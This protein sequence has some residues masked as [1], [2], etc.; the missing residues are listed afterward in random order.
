MDYRIF[1]PEELPEAIVGLP[2]S[3]S[4][5]N[6]VLIINAL[7]GG[8]PMSCSVARCDDTDVMVAALESDGEEISVG[9]AGTAMRF[10]TAY[11]A[12]QPGR[13]VSLDGSERMRRRPIA[14][15][16]DALRE[17]GAE[18]SYLG[19]EGFPP[20]KIVGK[21]LRGGEIALDGS[22]SSQFVSALLMVAPVMSEGLVLRLQGDVVSQPYIAMTLGIMAE[23]GVE[24]VRE[25]DVIRVPHGSYNPVPYHVEADWSAASYW[26]ELQSF[27]FGTIGLRGL[28][29]EGSLQG[30]SV[31]M[32]IYRNFGIV[33][34]ESEEFPGV[35]D[36]VADPD[37]TPRY[38]ADFSAMP[39]LAQTVG[40]SC[41]MLG[42]PFHITGL[43][44]LRIKETD[45][46]EALRRELMK[47]SFV[48][49]TDDDSISWEGAR[50]P[51]DGSS[52]I[53]IDTYD[54]HRMAMAFAP[55]AWY[56]PGLIIRNAEVVSKSYPDYWTHLRAAGF[57]I[58]PQTEPQEGEA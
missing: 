52:K 18:I 3:K 49:D 50:C 19:E 9:A 58:E 29:K 34:E 7:A 45:R 26:Y 12:A 27:S 47:I 17:C 20:L 4:I 14:P 28:M 31:L 30:D 15:L 22:V 39:D 35:L 23:W 36:L 24:S 2:L 8:A 46:L 1:P 6:R 51:V 37:M 21:S 11:F 44:T 33:T 40:V 56:V 32:K 53:A 13:T 55:V 54:D 25:G 10:L 48:V 41:C 43:K 5:S 16:V 38:E 42:V 57:V